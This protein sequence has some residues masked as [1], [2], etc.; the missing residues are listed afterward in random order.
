MEVSPS[1]TPILSCE[2]DASMLRTPL[3]SRD[4]CEEEASMLRTPLKLNVLTSSSDP[5]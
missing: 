3:Y 4:V 5:L 1:Q 2:V